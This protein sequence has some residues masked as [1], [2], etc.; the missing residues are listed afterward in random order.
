MTESVEPPASTASLRLTT[1][2]ADGH[3]VL[4]RWDASGLPLLLAGT[5]DPEVTRWTQ[6]PEGLSAFEAGFIAASWT[7]PNP[8]FARFI[9]CLGEG[10]PS[11][12]AMAWVEEDVAD[13]A[14]VGYWLL[15]PARGHGTGTRL[16][17]LLC[18]WLFGTCHMSL[19][20]LTTLPGN[21]RGEALARRAGFRACGVVERDVKGAVRQL[22]LW[23]LTAE[24]H[25]YARA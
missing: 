3:L 24:H 18:R 16:L 17:R 13:V 25:S 2:L 14:E 9:V 23:V 1:A 4:R 21:A 20:R 5:A 7:A 8:R 12:M 22:Q 15:A 6:L 19:I 10:Q 11:G